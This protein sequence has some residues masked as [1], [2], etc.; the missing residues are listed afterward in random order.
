[1]SNNPK[2][3]SA[4]EV[5]IDDSATFE[6][7]QLDSRL[8]QAVKGFGFQ[9]PTLIQSNAIPLALQQKRD[10][11]AKAAT[12]SGKTLAYLIPVI[13]TILDYKKTKATSMDLEEND[14]LGIILVPT[15]ELAQQVSNVLEKMILYCSNEIRQLNVS[16]DCLLY[17][18][19]CV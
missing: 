2:G 14:T 6:S 19:R 8:L 1:M 18:S 13:Q 3:S 12:G 4:S 11:I 7:F 9:H 15:R 10:I 5:Y 16:A 17:T